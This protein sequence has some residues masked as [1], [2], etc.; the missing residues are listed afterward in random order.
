MKYFNYLFNI[1]SLKESRLPWID[2]AKGVAII[3]V[4]YRHI[5]IGLDRSGI[6]YNTAYFTFAEIGVTFRMHLFFIISGIFIRRSIQKRTNQ[7][8]VSDKLKTLIYPYLIWTVLQVTLQ[9]IMRDYTNSHRTALDYLYIIIQPRAIDQFWFIYALFN[10]AILYLF[11]FKITKGNKW[12]LLGIATMMYAGAPFVQISVIDDIFDYFIF[13]VIGDIISSFLLSPEYK[14]YYN[15]ITLAALFVLFSIGIWCYFNFDM[16]YFYLA[17]IALLG[18]ALVVNLAFLV[19]NT[20]VGRFF[21]VFGFH[22][23]Y[24]YLMHSMIAAFVRVVLVKFFGITHPE[25]LLTICVL[26]GCII[27]IAICN[28]M[29]KSGLWFFFTPDNPLKKGQLTSA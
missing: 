2:F 23:V 1:D 6:E 27:P 19:S 11:L 20:M 7:K 18:S 17:V 29:L 9:I 21:R 24:L 25:L 15:T 12:I 26:S 22:S 13:L 8:F 5:L 14:K 16:N 10:V 3:F 28:I 4:V